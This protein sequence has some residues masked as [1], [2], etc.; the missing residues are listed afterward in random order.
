VYSQ[1]KIKIW[2]L[3][4]AEICH[5]LRTNIRVQTRVENLETVICVLFPNV[6]I[7]VSSNA[8]VSWMCVNYCSTTCLWLWCRRY[9]HLVNMFLKVLWWIQDSLVKIKIMS[10]PPPFSL[11]KRLDGRRSG[12]MNE[13]LD[14]PNPGICA[15]IWFC[16]YVRFD[17]LTPLA[18]KNVTSCSVPELFQSCKELFSSVCW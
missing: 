15:I 3:Y 2:I 11:Y 10:P 14:T 5:F 4:E 18:I 16:I 1:P 9:L 13:W 7:T 17:V 12:R 6:N 8:F